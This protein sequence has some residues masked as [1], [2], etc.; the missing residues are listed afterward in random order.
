MLQRNHSQAARAADAAAWQQHCRADS[1][2]FRQGLRTLAQRRHRK[3]FTGTPGALPVG[4]YTLAGQPAKSPAA[5]DPAARARTFIFQTAHTID[6]GRSVSAVFRTA[7]RH[8]HPDSAGTSAED[9]AEDNAGSAIELLQR[10]R[11]DLENAGLW[12]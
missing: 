5:Q 4:R 1:I 2:A 12:S 11:Q 3:L 10:A 6:D 9:D 8:V 7:L